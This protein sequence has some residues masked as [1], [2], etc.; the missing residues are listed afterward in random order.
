MKYE[1]SAGQ[2]GE[3]QLVLSRADGNV[4][5]VRAAVAENRHRDLVVAGELLDHVLKLDVIIACA[6]HARVVDGAVS[7][8]GDNVAG[9]KR[10]GPIVWLKLS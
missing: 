5:R 7:D 8:L 10:I 2:V 9:S 1:E 4:D 3:E 6:H